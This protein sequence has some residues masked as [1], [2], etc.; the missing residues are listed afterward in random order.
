MEESG[1]GETES[2]NTESESERNK[3][4]TVS[5][6]DLDYGNDR[7]HGRELESVREDRIRNDF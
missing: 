3:I 1:H 4:V 5:L 6:N 7:E 2:G